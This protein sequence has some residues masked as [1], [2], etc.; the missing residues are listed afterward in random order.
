MNYIASLQANATPLKTFFFRG[1]SMILEPATIAILLF[2]F[3]M[4][5]K[6]KKEA[7][8][9][10]FFKLLNIALIGIAKVLYADPR[11]FWSS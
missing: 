9:A 4:L 1:I 6:K 8:N 7:I 5:E 3:L 10:F 2:L 11:P